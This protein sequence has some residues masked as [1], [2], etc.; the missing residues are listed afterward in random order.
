MFY[1]ISITALILPASASPVFLKRDG[2]IATLA[3]N[4]R[5]VSDFVLKLTGED[6][7]T[8][9]ASKNPVMLGKIRW[10]REQ[11][12]PPLAYDQK[13]SIHPAHSILSKTDYSPMAIIK[14]R[15]PISQL[16]QPIF[17]AASFLFASSL[18]IAHAA[19]ITTE[20]REFFESKVRPVLAENCYSCHNSVDKMKGELALDYRGG[21][22]AKVVVPGDPAKSLLIRAVKH[23]KDI[24]A[25]PPK[26]PKL[27]SLSIKHL[28]EWI[29]MGA[30]DPRT[31]KPTKADLE[32]QT[33]WGAMRDRR[34][35]WWSFQPVV[36]AEPPQA[37]DA[38]WNGGAIDQFLYSTQIAKG[39]QPAPVADPAT[40]VRRL[41]LILTGLPP[42]PE[43]VAAFVAQPTENAYAALVDGL[44]ASPRYGER[45]ARYWMD[46][47]RYAES[48]GSEGDPSIP[49]A[50][51]Y[52]DYLIRAFNSDVRGDQLIREHL[53]GDL[54]PNPRVNSDLGINESA[55]GPAHLR[56]VP[57]GFGVTDAYDEQITFTDNQ[58]DVVT[59]AML[60]LT[61]SCARCHN[62]KF[63]PIS[64]AD[65]Y[66]FYGIMVS[67][68]PATVNVDSPEQQNLHRAEL[69]KLKDEIR[70]GFVALWIGDVDAA[71]GQ[72]E[73]AE[74]KNIDDKN[75]LGAWSKLRNVEPENFKAQIFAMR[76]AFEAG[77]KHNEETRKNATFY[78]D[79]RDQATF[80]QWSRTGNGVGPKVSPAGSFALASEGERVFDG[81]YPAGIYSHLISKKHNGVIGSIFHEAAG[82]GASVRA[83]GERAVVRFTLRSYPLENGLLH[84]WQRVNA[85]PN[86]IGMGKYTYWN[87][88]KGF[89]QINTAADNPVSVGDGSSWFGVLE[90]YAGNG[91]MQE[92]GAPLVALQETYKIA[93]R[94]SL[95]VFY[96]E[97]LQSAINAWKA[98]NMTDPQASLLNAFASQE[99]LANKTSTLPENLKA[100]VENYRRLESEIRIPKRAP[101]VIEG[102]V[103]DQPMLVRGDHKKEEAPVAR[104][105]LEVFQ[106][107]AYPKTGSGRLQLAN[108]MLSDRNTLT[109][110]VLVNRL[111]HHTF[112]RGIVASTD[113]FGKL[114]SEPTHPQLLDYLAADFRGNGWSM[115]KL[116]RGLVMSRAFRSASAP[117]AANGDKDPENLQLAYFTPRRLD[118]E[119]I[120]DTV[121]FLST[122]DATKR[123]V[124][125]PM[126]RNSLDV[127]L[128]AFNLPVP[129]STTGV[130][131]S[132]NVPA[133]ALTLMNGKTV[134]EA[135]RQWAERVHNNSELPTVEAKI[136]ALFKQAY[137]RPATP[138]ESAA[139]IEFL[140]G[141]SED[142]YFRIAHAIL[143]SKELIYVH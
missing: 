19:E 52:R 27:S 56:M 84:P 92:L 33:D 142:P 28:E 136:D 74:L 140:S 141:A 69:E 29:A 128:T 109:A 46:W 97:S 110:R 3:R 36:K 60:G 116:V 54:L 63:D 102:E 20:Q 55:I 44:L 88:E 119:A 23:D 104:G 117:P 22:L 139:C 43:V 143:N 91:E 96:R 83:F 75:P 115:K 123:A 124:F 122:N 24:E 9:I 59:K 48:H 42:A 105:F 15:T 41:H 18:A 126:K 30:P 93:D 65:F 79:L 68:R 137:A 50:P 4:L 107:Q 130:R 64:Q 87:G 76:A 34:A 57:H 138:A 106:G 95:L 1:R 7:S 121:R 78:A 114:G 103:W 71:I 89:F 127:F 26:A 133:Q 14:N 32:A 8:G 111:W 99:F 16:S 82:K 25:M 39:L 31:E 66:K 101:G 112:G 6:K 81:I 72:L 11:D 77:L 132:T 62:H 80:D 38:A 35:Q 67:S 131:N 58:I 73:K 86:W 53:A 70:N 45:W 100:L 21:V 135:A 47:Y 17:F 108:D 5:E 40:L 129:T 2:S 10:Q 85:T 134:N 125:T 113:N 37:E 118:A 90:A 13:N 51:Q 98:G 49:H 120:F 12:A 61:V 94:A